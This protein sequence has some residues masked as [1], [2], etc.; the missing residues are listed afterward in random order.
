LPDVVVPPTAPL[1]WTVFA[2]DAGRDPRRGSHVRGD[3]ERAAGQHG[4]G[5]R[6]NHTSCAIARSPWP[7]G[8]WNR[9]AAICPA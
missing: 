6:R 8:T 2:A 3:R 5:D 9:S 1:A 4:P 7:S